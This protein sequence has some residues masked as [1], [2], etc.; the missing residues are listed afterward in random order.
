MF[1]KHDNHERA[2]KTTCH[3][4][5]KIDTEEVLPVEQGYSHHLGNTLIKHMK[6]KALHMNENEQIEPEQT[7]ETVVEFKMKQVNHKLNKDKA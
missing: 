7:A 6:G 3:D 2:C 5:L 1:K 4:Y